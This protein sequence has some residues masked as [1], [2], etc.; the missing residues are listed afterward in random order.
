MYDNELTNMALPDDREFIYHLGVAVSVFIEVN[1]FVIENILLT[2]QTNSWSDL[3]DKES[4]KLLP[5]IKDTITKNSN[6]KIAKLFEE[7]IK[8][9]NRILHGF[10]GTKNNELQVIYTKYR[11]GRQDE[12]DD[13]FL[14]DF[15]NSCNKLNDALEKYRKSHKSS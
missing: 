11:D 10:R 1:G 9:R 4:G 2:D 8:K 3:I 7:C 12:I 13:A 15:I 5:H 14:I 6:T